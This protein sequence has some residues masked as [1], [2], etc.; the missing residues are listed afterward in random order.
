LD[1]NYP[2]M[3]SERS[4]TSSGPSSTS[5]L[6]ERSGKNV[7]VWGFSSFRYILDGSCPNIVT[8]SESESVFFTS[9]RVHHQHVSLRRD[10]RESERMRK[11]DFT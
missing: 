11:G 2:S 8:E 10:L 1:G 7:K 4:C 5:P 3:V 6:W 9:L